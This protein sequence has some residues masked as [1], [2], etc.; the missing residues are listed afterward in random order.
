MFKWRGMRRVNR[1][2]MRGQHKILG[3]DFEKLTL[4]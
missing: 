1:G 2:G 4:N 3:N